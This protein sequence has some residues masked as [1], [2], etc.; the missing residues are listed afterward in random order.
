MSIALH[1]T[2]ERWCVYAYARCSTMLCG[3]H[4]TCAYQRAA[5]RPPGVRSSARR[6]H[7]PVTRTHAR[8]HT[9]VEPLAQ[10]PLRQLRPHRPPRERHALER[11]RRAAGRRP[12]VPLAAA[13]GQPRH[14][15]RRRR[16]HHGLRPE[17]GRRPAA[18]GAPPNRH[19]G[20]LG[21]WV[22]CIMRAY[23][24]VIMRSK[25]CCVCHTHTNGKLCIHARIDMGVALPPLPLHRCVRA[26]MRV[27]VYKFPLPVAE[28]ST[29]LLAC[30]L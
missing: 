1:D 27:C 2:A 13:G 30:D 26:R 25:I 19:R 22:G 10:L 6:A 29:R 5:R 21:C 8:T 24:V 20:Q 18:T 16:R 15:H 11:R 4:N 12:S 14:P 7:A 23:A 9:Q 17:P 3:V 28:T